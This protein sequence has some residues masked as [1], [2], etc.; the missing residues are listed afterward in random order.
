MINI[1]NKVVK[2]YNC[3]VDNTNDEFIFCVTLYNEHVFELSNTLTSISA[4]VS[5]LDNVKPKDISVCVIID[6]Y[7]NIHETVHSF[8]IE[9]G[10]IKINGNADLHLFKTKFNDINLYVLIKENNK[11]KLDS[12]W[13]FYN[14]F[15]KSIQ[16]KYSIQI[17][18]GVKLH[19]DSLVKIKE[20]FDTHSDVGAATIRL[21]LPELESSSN[22]IRTWH[23]C[24]FEVEKNIEWASEQLSGFLTV[25]P[26]QCSVIRWKSIN[27]KILRNYFI[28]LKKSDPYTLN[29]FRTED[30][31]L[32]CEIATNSKI[33]KIRYISNAYAE[34]NEYDGILELLKQRKRWVN[35][36]FTAN[37]WSISKF[38]KIFNDD[39][40]DMKYKIHLSV[41]TIWTII[42]ALILWIFPALMIITSNIFFSSLKP[43]DSIL[44]QSVFGLIIGF[45]IYISL[46][47]KLNK[48]MSTV[49]TISGIYQT[50]LL[51]FGSVI[52]LLYGEFSFYSILTLYLIEALNNIISFRLY[53]KRNVLRITVEV[54]KYSLVRPVIKLILG[55]NGF[56]NV[57]DNSWGTKN[58]QNKNIDNKHKL[59]RKKFVMYWLIS[60]ALIISIFFISN[61]LVLNFFLGLMSIYVLFRIITA[62][63]FYIKKSP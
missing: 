52:Y 8:L 28:G 39:N 42:N 36:H 51:F 31:V 19:N 37:I 60:N 17:D 5:K 20:Y 25:L 2:T 53:T 38:L 4:A 56:T 10:Q 29:R 3:D 6:G 35:G 13:W 41:S 9:L 58:I 45:Q 12:H 49:L 22:I 23:Y 26:G 15:G 55:I 46:R 61:T 24:D 11:G 48:K 40:Y 59:Y 63:Y 57:H 30:R 50:I 14:L 43:I 27:N 21:K 47:W 54:I 34:S 62:S 1:E 16:P 32:G 44:F 7:D 18:T 33:P